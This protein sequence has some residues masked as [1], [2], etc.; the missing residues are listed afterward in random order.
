[1]FSSLVVKFGSK[2]VDVIEDA[3]QETFYKAL[4]SWKYNAYPKNPKGWLFTVTKN[5]VLNNLKRSKKSISFNGADI[6]GELSAN[7]KEDAQLQ[8]ILACAKLRIKDQSKL[9]FTLKHVC[10]FGVAEIANS[11]LIS[12]DN[13]YKNLQRAKQELQVVPKDFFSTEATV[14]LSKDDIRYIETIVY[15]MFN[16]GYDSVNSS[17]NKA[18]HKEICFEAVRLGHLLEKRSGEEGTKHILALCY[19]HMARFDSRIDERQEFVSLRNQDRSKWDQDLIQ[20]GFKYLQKP[21]SLNRYYLEAL[22]ASIHLGA[23][24][25]ADTNWKEILTLYNALLRMVD[26]PVIRL[27]RAICM[28]ELY[29]ND[30][31]LKELEAIKPLLEDN[32]LYF[33]VSMAEYLE[34]KDT[35]LAKFWY[36]KSL[37]TTK[38]EFRRKIILRKLEQLL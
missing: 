1:V 7:E 33:S 13:I 19:F 37:E 24:T 34:D 9:I 3:L 28:F 20:I 27:N 26:T 38:Q 22:I 29:M 15:C 32:Y 23:V 10:G 6:V 25:F 16:E 30:N 18:I 17:S 2:Y 31:A 35:A 12:K 4:K 14:P 5:H 36:Q 8:L 21:A 11:L